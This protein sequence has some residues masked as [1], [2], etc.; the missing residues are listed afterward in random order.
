MVDELRGRLLAEG[1]LGTRGSFMLDVVVVAM[2]ILIPAMGASIALVRYRRAYRWHR[3]IQLGLASILFLAVGAF[4]IEMR[5]MTDW[6]KLALPSPYYSADTWNAVNISLGIH[7]FFAVPTLLA[8]IYV[9]VQAIRHFGWYVEPGPY[10]PKHA[11]WG[12]LAS[13]GIVMTAVTGWIFY[14][15]AFAAT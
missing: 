6:T 4:E 3:S 8:W 15:L 13:L 1:F 12:R 5:M 10:G 11:F 7:L 2:A 14:W 9:I